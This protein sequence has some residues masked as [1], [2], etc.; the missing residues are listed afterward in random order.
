MSILSAEQAQTYSPS[1]HI[2][3]VRFQKLGK[4]YHFDYQD[5]PELQN[6]DL[7][8]VETVR[9]LQMGQVVGFAPREDDQRTYK[10]ILR[11]ATPR[12]LLMQQQWQAKEL[13]VLI[14]C[15]EAASKHR[16]YHD[17]K[18]IKA[19]YSFDGG[20]LTIMYTAED[21]I[22]A[23]S[24]YA[25]MRRKLN[26]SIDFRQIGPRDVARIMGG[27]G[28]CG[29]PRCCSTFLTEFSPI[30]IKMAKA[31]GIPLNPTEITGMC[32]RLRCCLVYEYEQYVEARKK[33]PKRNKIV[34]TPH[35][36]GR[37]LDVYPLRD[38]VSVE[39]EDQRHF[40]EREQII[41]LEEFRALRDKAAA[42]CTKNESGA[43]DC[44]ARRP[45]SATQDLKAALDLAQSAV[46]ITPNI[47]EALTEGE[48]ELVDEDAANT[49]AETRRRRKRRRRRGSGEDRP[50]A[51]SEVENEAQAEAAIPSSDDDA[52]QEPKKS[53]SRERRGR[54]RRHNGP[55][56]SNP[57]AGEGGDHD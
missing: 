56:R 57:S 31:Q 9:S 41:P 6:G 17:I 14:D 3:G 43:C 35:G 55:R 21:E 51:S 23:G 36:E 15:R 54:R 7:V 12:D 47:P 48:N 27:Q 38:G 49:P 10:T 13:E 53:P 8:V 25:E 46:Q 24:L 29:G 32:G 39:I 16:K 50:V 33:L 44:G 19:E 30:S 45:K 18:F 11:I 1:T 40:V 5:F 42:G 37:V 4:L 34:G 26:C 22:D 2:A 28:A 52:S 20:H